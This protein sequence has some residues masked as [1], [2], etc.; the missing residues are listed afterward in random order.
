M[1][2]QPE[3]LLAG[4]SLR[5]ADRELSAGLRALR[6]GLPSAA[7]LEQGAERLLLSVSNADH[8]DSGIR[9]IPRALRLVS[10]LE[11]GAAPAAPRARARAWRG[12]LAVGLVAAAGFA[13]VAS[14]ALDSSVQTSAAAPSTP[15]IVAAVPNPPSLAAAREGAAVSEALTRR[16]IPDGGPKREPRRSASKGAHALRSRV[17]APQ[18]AITRVS[19]RVSEP[20]PEPEAADSAVLNINSIPLSHVVLDGRPIGGTPRVQVEV[21]PGHHR[22]LFVHPEH[23]RK[24]FDVYVDSGQTVLAAVRFR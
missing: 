7:E 6:A 10:E 3:R 23:G 12:V 13:L 21:T 9:E 2:P 15:K 17:R 1:R 14:Q 22:V 19:A 16:A 24:L 5:A 4:R 11:P 20:E 18:P 8:S